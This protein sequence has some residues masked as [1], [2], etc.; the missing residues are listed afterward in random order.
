MQN[1]FFVTQNLLN[2]EISRYSVFFF[3]AATL[4]AL[5]GCG[6]GQAIPQEF[7]VAVSTTGPATASIQ[8]L[9]SSPQIDSSGANT[10]DLT[11]VVLTS[12]KQTISG[13][14]VTFSTGSDASAFINNI[15]TGGVTDDNGVVT[16]KLNVGSSKANRTITLSASSDSASTSASVDVTGTAVTVSGTSSLTSGATT[17]LI[18]SVKDSAGTALPGVTMSVT[19]KTGNTIVLTPS[20]GITNSAGQVSAAITAT[21]VGDDTITATAAGG[22]TTQDLTVS[23]DSFA[24]TPLA[25]TDIPL[26]TAQALSVNWTKNGAAIADGTAVSFSTSRG[27]VSAGSANTLAGVASGVTVSSATTAGPAIITAAGP[28]GT[29]AATL[30]VIFVAT[31][32][33]NVTAQAVPGT[34]SYTT[35]SA[36]QTNNSSTISVVVRDASNNLVKN[37]RVNFTI[38]SDPSAG[39]LTS[40]SVTTDVSG[41]ASVTYVAGATSS[42]S[43]GV[44]IAATVSAV[45]GVTIPAISTSTS[46]TVAGQA[47]LVSLGTDNLVGGLAPVN[48]KTYI[49]TVTDTGGNRVAGATVIFSLQPARFRKGTYV[50]DI[51]NNV[52]VQDI[53]ATCANED[54][55]PPAFDGI[56]QAGEDLNGNGKLD[57]GGVATVNTSAVTDAAGNATATITYPKDHSHWAEVTL[58]ARTGVAGNDPP[59]TVSFFLPG[60]A[61]DYTDLAVSPPGPISPYGAGTSVLCTN[62]L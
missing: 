54:A 58:V 55:S 4:A 32:A 35:G 31:S 33:S 49:A 18:F 42:P 13:K 60:A 23:A 56:I 51:I 46:L 21:A 9:V 48:T 15:S 38:T 39:K 53:K 45:N 40:S 3:L 41:S 22:T 36:S 28:G 1:F 44:V 34:I 6:S 25:N 27:S 29:P 47:N 43:N 14:T 52:W 62:T 57:P 50:A 30:D 11:A 61:A 37:A 8:L 5:S 7:P 20:T 59:T 2:R 17:T 10:V 24:F 16:A 26:G 19:S 12:T